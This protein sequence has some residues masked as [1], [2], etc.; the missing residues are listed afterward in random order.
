MT[1]CATAVTDA[2]HRETAGC[3]TSSARG[4]HEVQTVP[5]VPP[6]RPPDLTDPVGAPDRRDRA[7]RPT[8]GG[9]QVL[10]ADEVH[11]GED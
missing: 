4:L 8:K 9:C 10:I 1:F 7:H 11:F 3:P 2:R 6:G 5:G